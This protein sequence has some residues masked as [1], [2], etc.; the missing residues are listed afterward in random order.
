MLCCLTWLQPISAQQSQAVAKPRMSITDFYIVSGP[1]AGAS[2]A[3]SVDEF[4]QLAPGSTLLQNNFDGFYSNSGETYN[5]YGVLSVL[6]GIQF[7]DQ[8]TDSYRSN[9][10]LRVGFSYQSGSILSNYFSREVRSPYDTLRS[11]QTV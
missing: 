4:R 11:S 8:K 10:L 5:G 6:L 9:P 1:A 2:Q 3:G 7:R